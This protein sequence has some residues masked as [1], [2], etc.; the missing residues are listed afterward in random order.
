VINNQDGSLL[1]A[2]FNCS[3]MALLVNGLSLRETV[4]SFDISI[5][6]IEN[7]RKVIFYPSKNAEKVIIST[8]F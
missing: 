2:M 5:N 8:A 3:I 6:E 4:W 1:S 7:T